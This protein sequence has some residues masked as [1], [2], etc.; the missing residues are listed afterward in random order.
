MEKLDK[1][2]HTIR[3]KIA[4]KPNLQSYNYFKEDSDII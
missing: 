3:N 4:L 2:C 1:V